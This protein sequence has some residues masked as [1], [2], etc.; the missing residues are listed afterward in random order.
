MEFYTYSTLLKI[1]A[2]S[3]LDRAWETAA[4]PLYGIYIWKVKKKYIKKSVKHLLLFIKDSGIF[5]N[6]MPY[7]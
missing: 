3:I 7:G 1:T 5:D 6:I 2:D 4:V